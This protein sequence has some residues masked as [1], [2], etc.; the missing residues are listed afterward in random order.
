MKLLC[1]NSGDIKIGNSIFDGRGENDNQPLKEGEQYETIGEPYISNTNQQC[2]FIKGY[3][4]R[5]CCRFTK[6]IEEKTSVS[7]K[8]KKEDLILN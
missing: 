3:G 5:L 2:Y 1:I 7:F 8:V 6:L 4:S